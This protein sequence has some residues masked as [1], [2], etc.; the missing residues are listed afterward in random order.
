MIEQLKLEQLK[1]KLECPADELA[2]YTKEP[3]NRHTSFRIGGPAELLIMPKTERAVCCAV[4]AAKQAELPL[5]VLGNG[6]NVLV[7]DEGIRGV[8]L[9]IGTEYGNVQIDGMTVQAQTGALLSVLASEALKN[10][11]TGLEFAGGIPGSLGGA[12]F[13][14]AGAYGGQMADVVVSSRYY[15][16]Q[17]D[18]I[19]TLNG[20]E[21]A[22]GYRTSAYKD[23]PQWVALSATLQLQTG[24]PAEIK[25]K[26]DDF[27][28]RRRD[29]QPLNYPSAGSTFKRPEGY[30]AG[31]L[32]QDAGLRGFRV[33][34]A[35][36]SEK[37]TG[38][39]VNAGGATARD[40]RDLIAEVQRRVCEM[41]GVRM[42]PEVRMWGFE[43]EE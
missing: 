33:G 34:G 32:I 40:V 19:G 29:K 36:V 43:G 23:H 28:Q 41:E 20:K 14:D 11:L 42:Y 18:T 10:E 22:F 5:T 25:A 4:K 6:S 13:M 39:V 26:M 8:V 24:D 2:F 38:F 7:R 9:C 17:T 35:Q 12:L 16:A 31:K 37:H 3:M 1:S 27:S 15:D 30:F 21:H